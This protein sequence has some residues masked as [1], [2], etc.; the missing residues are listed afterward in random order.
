MTAITPRAPTASIGKVSESS[1]ESTV[2]LGPHASTT[3]V[4]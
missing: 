1:P 3:R 2:K 4:T